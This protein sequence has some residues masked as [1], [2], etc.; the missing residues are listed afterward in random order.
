MEICVAEYCFYQ[1]GNRSDRCGSADSAHDAASASGVLLFRP[2]IGTVSPVVLRDK[3][4]S[5]AS[6]QFCEGAGDD[7]E[8]QALYFAAGFRNADP[9]VSDDAESAGKECDRRI[10]PVQIYLFLYED[11]NSSGCLRRQPVFSY[12]NLG[13]S[14]S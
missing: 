9:G 4:V 2:G 11:Q 6:G 5:E 10:D 12:K 3:A 13:S 1:F 7:A 14:W 8:D